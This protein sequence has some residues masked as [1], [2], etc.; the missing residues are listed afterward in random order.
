MFDAPLRRLIDPW[1]N[2]VGRWVAKSGINANALTVT[3][4]VVGAGAWAAL[5]YQ[6]YLL[7]LA[8]ILG[9]R[10]LDGLD[11]AVAR[12]LGPTDVGAFLDITLDFLF[13]AGVPFF[14]AV[15]RPA[16]ALAAC[17]LAFSF[18]G[19]GTTFLAVAIIAA[20]R[21]ITSEKRGK[22]G[23][24]Y[25]GGLAEGAETILV[26]VALCLLP[27]WFSALAWGFGTVC[28][29]TTATRIVEGVALFQADRPN[30]G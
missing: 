21:G 4:F 28:L 29:V 12:H 1:A 10:L 11:G 5:A 26:F 16:E 23:I 30:K 17:F 22:K 24:F 19:T 13:Y 2:A 20:K 9:N 3:G 8:L 6:S 15:G 25:L 18:V 7:A 14:F 27:D